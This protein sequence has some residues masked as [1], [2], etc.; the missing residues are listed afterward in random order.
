MVY[1]YIESKIKVALKHTVFKRLQF[2]NY[3][4]NKSN[5]NNMFNIEIPF[6]NFNYY[7][8]QGNKC[9]VNNDKNNTNKKNEPQDNN[10]KFNERS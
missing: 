5:N 10:L 8:A 2:S 9:G 6:F 3:Y 7:I 4:Q 1:N